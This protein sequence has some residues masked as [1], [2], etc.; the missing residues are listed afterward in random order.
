[1]RASLLSPQR[2]RA[3]GLADDWTMCMMQTHA[4][5]LSA[6]VILSLWEDRALATVSQY[7]NR[8]AWESAVANDFTTIDFLG[9][10]HD[11]FIT[12][13]YSAE[14][15]ITFFGEN[16]ITGPTPIYQNDCGASSVQT[17]SA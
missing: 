2:V 9:F 14:H 7:T 10:L 13:Q 16:L 15:G 12:D 5:L 4:W 3:E 17:T 8:A 1:L 11:T 6:V